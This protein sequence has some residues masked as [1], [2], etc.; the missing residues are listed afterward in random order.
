MHDLPLGSNPTAVEIN[1]SA[2][3]NDESELKEN[4]SAIDKQT[5]LNEFLRTRE[6]GFFAYV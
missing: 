5:A 3:P 4:L 2:P 1:P 6:V